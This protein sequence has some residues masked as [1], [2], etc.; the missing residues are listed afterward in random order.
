MLEVVLAT[1]ACGDVGRGRLL[2]PG[3]KPNRTRVSLAGEGPKGCRGNGQ[4]L[5]GES[6]L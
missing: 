2:H 3:W 4:P 5:S 6:S 1:R